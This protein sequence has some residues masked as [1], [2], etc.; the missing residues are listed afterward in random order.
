MFRWQGYSVLRNGF[1]KL[2]MLNQDPNPSLAKG[3]DPIT[4]LDF[5]STLVGAGAGA[6]TKDVGI[7]TVRV[8]FHLALFG[9]A[10]R[11]S[12]CCFVVPCAIA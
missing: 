9:L 2:G 4:R 1:S 10:L 5:L 3:A 8:D 6:T 12:I 11:A 7:L